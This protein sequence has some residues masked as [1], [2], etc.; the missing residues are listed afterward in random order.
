MPWDIWESGLKLHA[1]L[2]SVL[3]GGDW[4]ASHPGIIIIIIIIWIGTNED[5]KGSYDCTESA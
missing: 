1:F 2:T 5:R 3:E 4:S